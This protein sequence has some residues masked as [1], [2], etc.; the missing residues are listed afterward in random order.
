[1]STPNAPLKDRRLR[2]FAYVATPVTLAIIGLFFLR[3]CHEARTPEKEALF[4]PRDLARLKGLDA[5][6]VLSYCR[7]EVRSANYAGVQRGSYGALWAGEANDWDKALLAVAALDGKGIEAR[8]VPGASPRVAFRTTAGWAV[9]RIDADKPDATAPNPPDGSV[10]TTE[11]VAQRPELFHTLTPV[12]MLER[13][14]KAPEQFKPATP[15]RLEEW[16]HEAVIMEAKSA[17]GGLV[18]VLRIGQREVLRSGPLADV[19]RASLEITWQFQNRSASWTREL[20]DR[21]NSKAE[22]PG[23]AEPRAGDRF[24]MAVAAGPLK[25]EVLKTRQRMMELGD[26]SPEP[27]EQVRQLVSMAV[28]YQID[29]DERTGALA[30]ECEVSVNWVKPRMTIAT[31]DDKD[32]TLDTLAD[33]VEAE[34]KRSREFHVARGLANDVIE[35]RII[36]EATRKPTVSASTVLCQFKS[37]RPDA[38]ARRIAM[39]E[40]EAK[41]I[42]ANE[43]IGSAAIFTASPSPA[44]SEEDRKQLPAAPPRLAIERTAQ[45]LTLRGLIKKGNAPKDEP[46]KGY[47]WDENGVIPFAN[48]AEL[49]VVLD[50]MLSHKSGRADSLL[51]CQVESAWPLR[52]LPVVQG[53]VLTYKV[54][55]RDKESRFTVKVDLK[56]GRPAGTWSDNETGKQGQTSGKWPEAVE[57]A[58]NQPELRAIMAAAPGEGEP[59]PHSLRVGLNKRQVEGRQVEIPGGKATLLNDTRVPLIL[60][61]SKGDL[62]LALESASPVIQGQVRDSD[63]ERPVS[64]DAVH[65]RTL[66]VTE[67][68]PIDLRKWKQQGPKAHGSWR[69]K[70]EGDFVEQRENG[71]P[72][73]FVSPD[74]YIDTTIRGKISVHDATDD[75]LIG[76]V[77][78]YQSPIADKKHDEAEYDFL[79]FD[80]KCHDQDAAREGFAL[81]RVKGNFQNSDPEKDGF[82]DHTSTPKFQTL[83]TDFG[84]GKGWRHN[85]EHQFELTYTRSRVKIAM[86]GKLIFD[87]KGVFPPGRFGFYNYSQPMVHY[88]GFS[89]YVERKVQIDQARTPT[90][91]DGSYALPIVAG[92][93]RLLLVLDRSGSMAFSLDPKD[94]TRGRKDKP[95]PPGQQRIDY[96]RKAVDGLLDQVPPTV[97]IAVWSFSS[98]SFRSPDPGDDRPTHVRNECPYTTD[99][100]R[101]RKALSGI[102]PDGSTPLSGTVLKI[103]QH[104]REDPHGPETTVVLLTDGENT[105]SITPVAAYR[106]GNGHF[107]IHTIGFAI[108]PNGKAE[109]AMR[110][111]AAAGGG[112]FRIAGTGDALKL[113]FGRFARLPDALIRFESTCHAPAEL[114][115]SAGEIGKE[116][117]DVRLSHGCAMC[118]CKDKTLLT[119]T[120]VSVGRLNECVGLSPKA[121][122]MIEARVADGKWHVVIPNRRVDIGPVSAYGWWE[123]ETA[124]GRMVGRTEDGLHG[125]S[126]GGGGFPSAGLGDAG[127]LPF[128]A[129]YT[130][131]VAYTTGSVL[132]A[133]KYHNEPGFFTGGSESFVRFVQANALDFCVRWW[134]EVGSGAFPENIHSYWSGVCMNFALQSLATRMPSL[135]CHRAWGKALCDQAA[136]AMKDLPNDKLKDQFGGNLNDFNKKLKTMQAE[137]EKLGLDPEQKS[138]FQDNVQ[139]LIDNINNLQDTWNS[140]VDQGF[141]CSR[142]NRMGK[143]PS[144]KP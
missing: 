31:G 99:H 36:Y 16:A 50:G 59:T 136:G 100:A 128:V 74:D 133:M 84:P 42:L 43:P 95:T 127:H 21:E 22:I 105:G 88:Q 119:I 64:A 18:Y 56:N 2:R 97:E 124:T 104:L 94:G 39:I 20:F 8:V 125:A 132:A 47:D 32:M 12:L 139:N 106:Q 5:E 93:E 40:K 120:N 7:E 118:Q 137:V 14:G 33:E 112:T 113:A 63:T 46:W 111:L 134:D 11:L 77:F 108:E 131:I 116:R 19:R 103:L 68:K 73:F 87:V 23:Q 82:W 51:E 37:D 26:Y 89:S 126:S 41:R 138:Q 61:W 49:A 90:A 60:S 110:D 107:P 76:F 143:G 123:T 142:F 144:G 78:G 96:V 55:N 28:K 3:G 66:T 4:V 86:D 102:K 69:V 75:D 9:W 130:G 67:R 27:D 129:W 45:G 71:K 72:T 6:G 38:P 57:L 80:W 101:V 17:E 44:L 117:Q 62:S 92:G 122:R 121:R 53:S 10:T 24:V 115:V 70:S 98:H 35:T 48:P 141:D 91:A 109:Q 114:T 52:Q 13:E 135:D 81:S 34:G 1:M 79:L 15:E 30:K 29:S 85:K 140:G 83:A 54:R 58:A 65:A 25:P